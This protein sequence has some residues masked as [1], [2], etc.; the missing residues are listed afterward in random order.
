MKVVRLNPPSHRAYWDKLLSAEI[1]AYY[2]EVIFDPVMA[3]LEEAGL[4]PK[5]KFQAIK[6]DELGGKPASG[7]A[8]LRANRRRSTI[9]GVTPAHDDQKTAVQ[10]ALASGA[11]W[12]ADGKFTG[13][14]NAS[15]SREL[16][17]MGARYNP[18]AGTFSLP[19]WRLPADIKFS[20][21]DSQ[22]KSR[23]LH[24]EI[25]ALLALMGANAALAETGM[26][27]QNPI[28]TINADLQKQ[29][30]DSVIK[31]GSDEVNPVISP[32][33]DKELRDDLET[34]LDQSATDF[35]ADAIPDLADRVKRNLEEG[36]R[37][38]KLADIV[39]ARKGV[40][41]RKAE[42]QARQA[43]ER[44]KAKHVEESARAIGSLSYV[45]ETR[46]DDRVRHDHEILDGK[47]FF[48]DLPPIADQRTGTRANPGIIW[49]CR[50]KA[51]PL[52][53]L[54]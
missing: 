1:M 36:G 11:I 42:F 30:T 5:K 16:R 29:F 38:D 14:F 26:N 40:A 46:H 51:Q 37:T 31:A 23:N 13:R 6:Y 19:E 18:A 9:D 15:I 10:L 27:F 25:L 32:H 45:W 44:A 52:L 28:D 39:E 48:W 50:C 8:S 34:Y 53:M 47:T 24:T 12:Y 20:V 33:L 35:A 3:L 43:A 21:T 49:N 17:A 54:K 4:R 22:V 2:D 7:M 41:K